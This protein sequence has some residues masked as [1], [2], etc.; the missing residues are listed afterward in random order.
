MLEKV[1]G[2]WEESGEGRG[3]TR[4]LDRDEDRRGSTGR[5]RR[6]W[7]PAT[8]LCGRM[9]SGV[10]SCAPHLMR[11]A[12]TRG[13]A[14]SQAR[15]AG[16]CC[17]W[18]WQESDEGRRGRGAAARGGQP[19]RRRAR[20]SSCQSRTRC[21]QPPRRHFP[22]SQTTPAPPRRRR[23]RRL[24]PRIAFGV[25][26]GYLCFCRGLALRVVACTGQDA[27]GLWAGRA[28]AAAR[29]VRR[30]AEAARPQPTA[31]EAADQRVH[32]ALQR[33]RLHKRG[34]WQQSGPLHFNTG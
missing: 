7:N 10:K 32:H 22:R 12:H 27:E 9:K 28:A 13:E 34:C 19:T 11:T 20:R 31:R 18:D 1:P 14:S 5:C 23:R 24:C 6:C 25:D 29:D 21:R 33:V 26:F 2:N 15:T 17:D 16:K 3:S 8:A 4:G 30:G